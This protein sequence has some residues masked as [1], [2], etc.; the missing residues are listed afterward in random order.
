M[1]ALI[2][3]G[4]FFVALLAFLGMVFFIA[5]YIF[6][7]QRRRS[8]LLREKARMDYLS[9]RGT[10][11]LKMLLQA[12]R[13]LELGVQSDTKAL[14]ESQAAVNRLLQEQLTELCRVL[15]TQI[16]REHI[17][18]IPGIGQKL[19][20]QIVSSVFRSRLSD[21]RY[22]ESNI[23]GIG[24]ARQMQIN[25]WIRSWESRMPELLKQDFPGKQL[26]IANFAQRIRQ[27]SMEVSKLGKQKANRQANYGKCIRLIQQLK[28]VRMH[29]FEGAL[30][31][32]AQGNPKIQ[33]YLTGV[34][35]EW[36]P[37]PDWFKEIISE[38]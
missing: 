12:Q 23:K 30:S 4:L 37:M 2:L 6:D 32:N 33:F 29:D 5:L 36:E 35:P 22:A 25:S 8:R 24:H 34:F 13:P 31:G 27:K 16:L 18:E 10:A 38:K 17:H 15:E 7:P 28:Q 9:S 14:G 20:A 11:H 1:N 19:G 3:G 26:V 21:L